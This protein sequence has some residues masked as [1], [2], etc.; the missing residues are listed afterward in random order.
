MEVTFDSFGLWLRHL[1][2]LNLSVSQLDVKVISLIKMMLEA[3]AF[4]QDH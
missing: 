1:A 2:S 3:K 4:V